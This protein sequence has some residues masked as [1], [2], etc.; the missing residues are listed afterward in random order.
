[1]FIPALISLSCV[2]TIAGWIINQKEHGR[3]EA[4]GYQFIKGDIKFT[5]ANTAKLIF[6]GFSAA[7]LATTVG[8][9][10]AVAFQPIFV[11]LDLNAA[12]ASATS[13]YL[14]MFTT[15]AATITMIVFQRLDLKYTLIINILTIIATYPGVIG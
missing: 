5:N 4:A 3:K 7:F 9:G 14:G 10:P 11:Q 1:M 12:I 13:C 6:I 15:G 2:A 8:L